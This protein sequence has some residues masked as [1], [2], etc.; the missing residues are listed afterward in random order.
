[1][2]RVAGLCRSDRRSRI[3]A[4]RSSATVI[5]PMFF[6]LLLR[7]RT[8]LNPLKARVGHIIHPKD[9]LQLS[10]QSISP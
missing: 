3:P 7:L 8:K 6:L 2:T 9:S 1:M 10:K 4:P 5:V